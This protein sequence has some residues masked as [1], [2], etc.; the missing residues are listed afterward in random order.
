MYDEDELRDLKSNL[1]NEI[2]RDANKN[3]YNK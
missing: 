1:K 3:I 2:K